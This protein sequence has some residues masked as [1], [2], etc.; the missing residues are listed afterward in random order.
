MSITVNSIVYPNGT[1]HLHGENGNS[2]RTMK[3]SAQLHLGSKYGF[4]IYFLESIWLEITADS[5]C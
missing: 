2:G 4:S 3:R 1:L 5:K